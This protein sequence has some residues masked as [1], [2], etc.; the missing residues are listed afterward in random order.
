MA[1]M[2]DVGGARVVLADLDEIA[3]LRSHIGKRQWDVVRETDYI[4]DPAQSGYRGVHL[5]VRK[6]SRLVEIQLR[7]KTM[8]DWA[9]TVERLGRNHGIEFKSGQGPQNILDFLSVVA[10]MNNA[11]EM[12]HEVSPETLKKY[13]QLIQELG[14][15][16]GRDG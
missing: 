7:T 1:R 2:Q 12:E 8:H 10:D 5:I 14:I 9:D 15:E 6:N 3:L 16:G 13:H 11:S 4:L